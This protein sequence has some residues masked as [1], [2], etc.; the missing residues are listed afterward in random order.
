MDPPAVLLALSPSS[1][2]SSIKEALACGIVAIV[3]STTVYGIT[4][5][6]AYIYF[7]ESGQDSVRLRTFV[8]FLFILDTASLA[9]TVDALWEYVVTDFGEM[10]LL[11][12][13]PRT[14]AFENTITYF[15][16]T[17]TQF[18]FA[19]HLWALSKGSVPLVS[20]IIILSLASLGI[21]IVVCIRNYTEPNFFLLTTP[22]MLWLIGA[23]NGL[24][25]P[26]DVSITIGLSYYLN[27]KR[28]GFKRTDS[29]I[30]WLIIYAVNRRALTA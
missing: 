11:L 24:S 1:I 23:A 18:F 15:I 13:L 6:Q 20:T 16:A 2:T 17:L 5:L 10:W 25:V 8:A 19:R 27:S 9:L 7:R 22:K 14:L 29:I 4:V 28:T 3:I 30:N 26:C 21:G 12:K